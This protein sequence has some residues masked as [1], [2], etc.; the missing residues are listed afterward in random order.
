[1]SRLMLLNATEKLCGKI[2][3][4]ANLRVARDI[5]PIKTDRRIMIKVE[6]KESSQIID[7][8]SKTTAPLT[9]DDRLD[10][11]LD[12]G[13]LNYLITEPN[14]KEL[15]EALA[16]Y[17]IDID[18]DAFDFV[19]IDSRAY[20]IRGGRM[21]K[22]VT[23]QGNVQVTMS[24]PYYVYNA[25]GRITVTDEDVE[26][27]SVSCTFGTPTARYLDG[28]INWSVQWTSMSAYTPNLVITVNYSCLSNRAEYTNI[29]YP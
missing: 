1:M 17:S 3:L 16:S 5:Y 19:G 21:N 4:Q 7:L 29:K 26:I 8:S 10:A 28:I 22:T 20:V 15:N 13:T 6:L 18:D 27:L 9:I 25:S 14:G 12:S 23:Q 24:P 11:S 2:V